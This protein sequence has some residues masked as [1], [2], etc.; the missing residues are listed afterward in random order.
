MDIGEI[1]LSV[2]S[3]S[4]HEKSIKFD[5]NLDNK[6]WE[7]E[8]NNCQYDVTLL[9]WFMLPICSRVMDAQ[10]GTRYNLQRWV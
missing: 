6:D 2:G 4:S 7:E 8:S 9:V 5:L 1:M 3:A 10:S